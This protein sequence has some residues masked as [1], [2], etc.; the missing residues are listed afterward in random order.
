MSTFKELF[1]N[2]FRAFLRSETIERLVPEAQRIPGGLVD[3]VKDDVLWVYG[4]ALYLHG[5]DLGTAI[6]DKD[7]QGL[8]AAAK[9]FDRQA[10]ISVAFLN[11]NDIK[12]FPVPTT[13]IL[14][15]AP[16]DVQADFWNQLQTLY[17]ILHKALAG[18]KQ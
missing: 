7:A 6:F 14:A 8:V 15:A 16:E 4:T 1:G 12:P 9:E 3:Q 18:S 5:S 10:N 2:K 17:V 13:D 11:E